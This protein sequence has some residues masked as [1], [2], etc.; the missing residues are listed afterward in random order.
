MS[1]ACHSIDIAEYAHQSQLASSWLRNAGN[2]STAITRV[3]QVC[4]PPFYIVCSLKQIFLC[5]KFQLGSL[6]YCSARSN[7]RKGC[8]VK[9]KQWK[10]SLF[11]T[12]KTVTFRNVLFVLKYCISSNSEMRLC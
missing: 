10:Y 4:H 2:C 1:V 9:I 8:K 5:L 7:L 12:K 11:C 6:R 3:S